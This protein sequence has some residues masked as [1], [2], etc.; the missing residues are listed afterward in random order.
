MRPSARREWIAL[1]DARAA[2]RSGVQGGEG[3]VTWHARDPS[4]LWL[5]GCDTAPQDQNKPWRCVQGVSDRES[6]PEVRENKTRSL[7]HKARGPERRQTGD[8]LPEPFWQ[9]FFFAVFLKFWTS[10]SF[11]KTSQVLNVWLNF[12]TLTQ[13]ES[14]TGDS[15]WNWIG[16]AVVVF[17]IPVLY[18]SLK[19]TGP[20]WSLFSLLF[21]RRRYKSIKRRTSRLKKQL[22]PWAIRPSINS[23]DPCA[24][25]TLGG[26]CNN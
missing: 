22:L 18:W 8:R 3:G 17:D 23:A 13:K 7:K 15:K 9:L 26:K 25:C 10:C 19:S 6:N 4:R 1:R 24:T 16:L 14:F 21:S 5:D 2:S 20:L 12:V 11:T